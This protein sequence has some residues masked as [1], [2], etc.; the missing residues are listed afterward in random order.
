M[1]YEKITIDEKAIFTVYATETNDSSKLPAI[2][3]L[4]GGAMINTSKNEG[5]CVALEFHNRGFQTYVL[6]YSTLTNNPQHCQFPQPA[7]ELAKAVAMIQ[8][9]S[10][11]WYTD[12]DNIFLLGFSAGGMIASYYGNTYKRIGENLNISPDILKPKGLVLCYPAIDLETMHGPQADAGLNVDFSEVNSQTKEMITMKKL[13]D[14][15]RMA[16]YGKTD[17]TVEDIRPFNPIAGINSETSDTFIWGT[18]DDA[19]VPPQT[20]YNYAAKL[21]EYHIPHEMH[22]FQNG[23][24]GI[25]LA[26]E[27]SATKPGRSIPEIYEWVTLASNWMKKRTSN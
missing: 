8:E 3:I 12:P 11:E 17:V 25:S 15:A 20:L 9:R 6:D 13:L 18:A 5:E 16:M 10:D 21:T 19:L 4:P 24:H 7:H 26:N 1:L 27:A 23:M 14:A 2:I 22:L